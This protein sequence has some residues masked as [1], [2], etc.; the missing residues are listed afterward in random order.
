LS[1]QTE[2]LAR[3]GVAL[4]GTPLNFRI[5]RT[6]T[7]IGIGSVLVLIALVARARAPRGQ[8]SGGVNVLDLE[9]ASV[10]S[11]ATVRGT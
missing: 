2:S 4:A 1:A 9:K 11:R 5:L 8:S 10:H 7:V 3:R 6:A